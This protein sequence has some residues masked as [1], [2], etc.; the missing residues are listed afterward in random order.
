MTVYIRKASIYI[1]LFVLTACD[2]RCTKSHVEMTAEEVVEEYIE[3]SLNIDSVE[4]KDQLLEYTTGDLKAAL[5]GT[6]DSVFRLAYIDKKYDLI[7]F[8]LIERRDRTPRETEV[9]FLIVYKIINPGRSLDEEPT[10]SIENTVS[11]IKEKHRWLIKEVTGNKTTFDFPLSVVSEIKASPL[12]EI[13][14]EEE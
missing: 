5:A 1:F 8:S 9:T 3:F 11:L 14:E 7:S 13:D 4:Q 2:M 6:S 12:K 10:M